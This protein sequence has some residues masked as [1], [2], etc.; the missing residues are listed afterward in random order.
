M[1]D[2]K[3]PLSLSLHAKDIFRILAIRSIADDQKVEEWICGHL[4][5][6]RKNIQQTG[7]I[8]SPEWKQRP[9]NEKFP[10]HT[11]KGK[12]PT[13]KEKIICKALLGETPESTETT[14]VGT[15]IDYELPLDKKRNSAFGEIDLVSATD[16]TLFLFEVKGPRCNEA[17]IRAFMEIFTFWNLLVDDPK[18][19]N[20][21]DDTA[22][23]FLQSYKKCERGKKLDKITNIKPALLLCET[24][25]IFRKLRNRKHGLWTSF[26]NIPVYTYKEPKDDDIEALANSIRIAWPATEPDKASPG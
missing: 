24:S 3:F 25:P 19:D 1:S 8:C 4:D 5:D 17:P 21:T 2:T 23:L 12:L 15:F 10:V 9:D 14:N 13:R 20:A 16:D 6:I 26:S 11:Q 22:D 18:K 7:R